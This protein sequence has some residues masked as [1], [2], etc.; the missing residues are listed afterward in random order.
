DHPLI[1]HKLTH[2]RN[3]ETNTRDFRNNLDEIASLMAYEITRDLPLREVTIET[4]IKKCLTRELAAEIVLVPI[5]RAGL[6]MVD[7]ITHLIPT[8]KVG[9][10][11]LYRNEKTLEPVSYYSKYPNNLADAF[12]MVLDPMLATGGSASVAITE[13]KKHGV[14]N[15]KL[16]CVVGAPEG[17]QKIEKE[18]P[19]VEIVLAVL[20]EG[21]N[22]KGYIIPGL[23]DAGDRIFGTK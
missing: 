23:G 4:P 21:L 10:L 1:T 2:L 9:H 20:D 6:G 19:N 17:V 22:D 15:L 12:V 13:L 5:L 14:K 18:H 3:K 16:V 7:G 8:A 11:G